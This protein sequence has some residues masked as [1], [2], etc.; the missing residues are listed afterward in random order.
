M[1]YDAAILIESLNDKSVEKIVVGHHRRGHAARTLVAA[2]GI[3]LGEVERRIA[4]QM[5]AAEDQLAT[6]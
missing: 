6:T 3:D 4:S 2:R 5:A 1:F